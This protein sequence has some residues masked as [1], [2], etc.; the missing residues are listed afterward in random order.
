MSLFAE[1]HEDIDTEN[2]LMDTAGKEEGGMNWEGSIGTKVS[3]EILNFEAS[4]TPFSQRDFGF[5]E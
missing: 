3:K 5:V 2:R 1:Q 4:E